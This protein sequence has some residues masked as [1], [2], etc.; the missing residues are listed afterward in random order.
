MIPN[1][2][3]IFQYVPNLA[4]LV[5]YHTDSRFQKKNVTCKQSTNNTILLL[6]YLGSDV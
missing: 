6:A 1:N 3:F 2:I 5:V 4:R